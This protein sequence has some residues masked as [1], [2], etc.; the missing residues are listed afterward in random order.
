MTASMGARSTDEVRRSHVGNA[1]ENESAYRPTPEPVFTETMQI[2]IVVRD[3]DATL[4]RYA[5]DYGIGPWQL[6]EVTPENAPDLRHDGQP[7]KGSTRAAVTMVGNVMWE[8]IQPLYE[9]GIFARFLAEKGEGVHHIAVATPNFDDVVAEQIR[10]GN[11]L[12]LSGSFSGVEVAYLPTD[13]D[14]GVIL[15]IFSGF[16]AAEPERDAT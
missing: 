13:R 14:L 7:V 9:Q 6:F 1:T 10:R 4:R 16:P 5:D 8:L 15:E 11:T 3:L 2:G 12:P